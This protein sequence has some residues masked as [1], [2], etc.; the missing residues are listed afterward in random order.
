MLPD[1]LG[2]S[3]NSTRKTITF[4]CHGFSIELY[5]YIE[6]MKTFEVRICTG[7]YPE[8]QEANDTNCIRALISHKYLLLLFFFPL[9]PSTLVRALNGD[10]LL[11]NTKAPHSYN[12]ITRGIRQHIIQEVGRADPNHFSYLK[13][14]EAI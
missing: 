7:E 8:C 6:S 12:K 13:N 10:K 2:I 14:R 1:L 9:L 5:T 4:P 11:S 3:R